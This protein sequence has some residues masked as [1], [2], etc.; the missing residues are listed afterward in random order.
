MVK[1]CTLFLL[2]AVLILAACGTQEE[3]GETPDTAKTD[4]I[5]LTMMTQWAAPLPEYELMKSRVEAFEEEHPDIKIDLETVAQDQYMTKLRTMATGRELPDLIQAWPGAELEPLVEGGLLMPLDEEFVDNWKDKLI[6]SDFMKNYEIDG[7][8]YAIPVNVSF[9]SFIFYNKELLA[10]AGYDGIPETY[11]E[12]KEMIIALKDAGITPIGAGNK[13]KW[14][15]QSSYLSVISDRITGSD[16]LPQVLNGEKKFTDPEFIEALA[17]I[18]ELVELEAFNEDINTIDNNQM[19]DY[20][21]QG[22]SAITIEGNWANGKLR[23][24]NPEGDNIGIAL[25]PAIEGGKGS[26]DITS[27]VSNGG[28]ALNSELTE[29]KKEAAYKF[30]EFFHSEEFYQEMQAVQ[31][32]PAS[33]DVPDGVDD[34]IIDLIELTSNGAAPVLDGILPIPVTDVLEDGIQGIILGETT[35]EQVAEEMQQVLE[36]Q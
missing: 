9:T 34:A 25:F 11:E 23:V 7:K 4:E 17:V 1:R 30:L 31:L 19:Q 26:P 32:T 36:E 18:Q 10:E 28:I 6:S 3:T 14:P 29:E 35:P 16:F 20:F 2:S 5:V 8:H 13:A 33:V 21:M 22:R 24:D 15:L 12:F 27:G